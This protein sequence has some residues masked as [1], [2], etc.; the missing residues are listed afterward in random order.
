MNAK[1]QILTVAVFCVLLTVHVFASIQASEAQVYSNTVVSVL[2]AQTNARE[3]E[4]FSVN[5]T[6]SNVENLYGVD[7]E[8]GWNNSALTLVSAALNLGSDSMPGGVLYG[9]K[10]SSDIVEGDVYAN[11]SLS[12]VD[13]YRLFA[14]SVAPAASFNGSGTIATLVFNVT[15]VGHSELTLQSELADHPL[16]GETTSEPIDHTDVNGSVDA[17]AFPEFP[18]VAVLGSLLVLVT[19]TVL[20]FKKKLKIRGS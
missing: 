15:S 2:P 6:I 20:A 4:T 17:A 7:L 11:T 5:I 16:P 19:I 10:I 3:G 13:E 1:L 9:S 14:T 8:V 18:V 12:T